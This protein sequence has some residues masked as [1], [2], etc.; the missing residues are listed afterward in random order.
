MQNLP[1]IIAWGIWIARNRSIFLD[2]DTPFETIAIQCT[3]I[4][5]NILESEEER[6]P[7]QVREEQIKEGI[8]WEFFDGASQKNRAGAGLVIN[9]NEN[10]NLKASVCLGTGSNNF[11]ELSALKFL[12]CWLIHRN[13]FTVHIFGDSLNVIKWSY[14]K[15]RCQNYILIP[16]LEEIQQLKLSFNVFSLCHIYRECNDTTGR[17]SKEG[18]QQDMGCWRIVGENH[19][20]IRISDQPPYS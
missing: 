17:F 7:R 9:L 4:Y 20:E 15:S 13:I 8:P 10:Q 19:G 18:L 12:L 14:G 1:P 5:T 11:E 2:K 6:T 3:S 16:L